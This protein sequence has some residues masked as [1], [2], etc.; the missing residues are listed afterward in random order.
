MVWRSA[1][2]SWLSGIRGDVNAAINIKVA[3]GLSETLNGRGDCLRSK[4]LGCDRRSVNPSN[5]QQLSIF[6]LLK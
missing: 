6:D 4:H 3:G 1:S 2:A 5:F